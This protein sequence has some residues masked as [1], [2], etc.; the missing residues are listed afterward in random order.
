MGTVNGSAVLGETR[1]TGD[2]DGSTPSA[3]WGR[4]PGFWCGM[5][6]GAGLAGSDVS[7]PP[8]AVLR[9]R[10]A[11]A[12]AASCLNRSPPTPGLRRCSP[13]FRAVLAVLYPHGHGGGHGAGL[14]GRDAVDD[15]ARLEA[16]GQL[17]AAATAARERELLVEAARLATAGGWQRGSPTT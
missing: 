12:G 4:Q 9:A 10:A 3:A 14:C 1:P 6:P 16:F 7:F 11:F 13:V 2:D 15:G 8:D 17:V 5:R